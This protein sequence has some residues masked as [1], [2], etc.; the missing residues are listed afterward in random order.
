MILGLAA[1]PVHA[2][3]DSPAASVAPEKPE[4]ALPAPGRSPTL[5]E[6]KTELVE[7]RV[8]G[9]ARGVLEVRREAGE[10]YLPLEEVASLLERQGWPE[11]AAAEYRLILETDP[12]HG[13]AHARLAALE[14]RSQQ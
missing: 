7:T 4:E 14:K 10:L 6:A 11:E 13:E 3:Q 5:A 9:K 12:H 8:R 2:S 1:M